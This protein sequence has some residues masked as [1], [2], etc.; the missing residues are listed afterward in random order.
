MRDHLNPQNKMTYKFRKTSYSASH[1]EPLWQFGVET[2]DHTISALEQIESWCW[3]SEEVQNII[4]EINA[5][6]AD[7]DFKYSV[8]GGHLLIMA[9]IEE[10]HLFNLLNESQTG[11]DIVWTT[12]RFI[13]FLNEFKA[14]LEE[15]DQ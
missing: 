4:D 11:A 10:T 1:I 6:T 15:N 2:S 7:D 9:D 14:F 8:E 5:I 12:P 13:Q 3:T